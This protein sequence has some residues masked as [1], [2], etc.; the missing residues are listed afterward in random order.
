MP[1]VG[2]PVKARAKLLDKAREL[3]AAI[4]ANQEWKID[5]LES[6]AHGFFDCLRC[7]YPS[8][9]VGM[10]VMDY[11]DVCDNGTADSETFTAMLPRLEV[12][13]GS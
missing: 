3:R 5:D 9:V 2:I 8:E 10:L 7:E 11:D 6:W 13:D 12:R 1:F 4:S